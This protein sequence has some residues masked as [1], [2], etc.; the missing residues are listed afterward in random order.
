[1]TAAETQLRVAQVTAARTARRED[2]TQAEREA[3]AQQ[4]AN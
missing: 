3:Y 2:M 4:Q 1:M